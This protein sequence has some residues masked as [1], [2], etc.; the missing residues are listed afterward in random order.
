MNNF[1]KKLFGI[2]EEQLRYPIPHGLVIFSDSAKE[3][4]IK[5]DQNK[6]IVIRLI[7][8]Y[9]NLQEKRYKYSEQLVSIFEN[10]GIPIVDKT[11]YE[12]GIKI[13]ATT[14]PGLIKFKK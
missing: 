11:K 14:D 1:F 3:S 10:R 9:G 7:N 6:L 2:K 12:E 13:Y 8:R 4:N 5:D